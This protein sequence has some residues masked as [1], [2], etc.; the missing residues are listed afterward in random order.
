M[1][2]FDRYSLLVS[3]QF[4]KHVIEIMK[5]N[6]TISG[7][8]FKKYL[9]IILTVLSFSL[10][11]SVLANSVDSYTAACNAGPVYSVDANVSNVN[12]TSNYAWQYKNTSNVWVCI[13]NGNNFINGY[14]YSIS[15]ATS[16]ATTNPNPIMFNNPNSGLQG[17]VIRCV[18]SNGTGV[19]PCTM[20][21]GN[22]W[23]SGSSSNNHTI[24]VTGSACGTSPCTGRV[25]RLYFNELN[26]GAD[27]QITNGSSFTVAQL[28]SLY[29]LEAGTTGAIGSIKY[30]ITGPTPT[31]NIENTAPY[32]SPGTGSGAWT[33]TLGTYTVNLK[34]YSATGATGN[35]CHDTTISFT[36]TNTP[37]TLGGIS[38]GAVSNYLFVFTNGSVD[39]NWQSASKGFIGNVAV[40]GLQASERT[41]GSFAYAGTIYTNDASLGAWQ[42]IVNNNLSQ[43]SASLNRTSLLAGLENDLNS[44]F[45]QINALPVSPGYN[46]V[47][48]TALNGLNKQNGIAETFVININSGFGISSKIN[49]TGDAGDVFILRWDTD[50]NPANGYQGQVKFQS[51]GAIVPLGGLKPSNFI[52]VAGDIASSG[53]GSNPAAPYPQGPR[54]N[55]GTGSLINGG[56]DFSGGGFFTGYWFTTGDPVTNETSSLS[57]AIFVGGW[58][59][60]T[61][62]FSMT[63]GT[64]G[65]Y[66]TPPCGP[67]VNT[68]IGEAANFG[69]L[70]L[71]NGTFT[72]NSGTTLIANVGYSKGVTSGTNQKITTFTGT[73]YVHSLV[74]SFV[75]DATTYQ[76]SGGI[77]QNN[78]AAD[79][80]LNAA[81]VGAISGSANYASLTPN[82]SLGNVITNKTINRVNNVT[83][84][85]MAS[86]NYNSNTITFVGQAG[87][88]DA[89]IINVAGSF[90]FSQS[91]VV[92]TNVRP[93]RVVWNFPNASNIVINKASTIF[94]GTILAPLG[95]VIYHNPASFE[96]AI[97]AK[98]IAVHS[99]FNLTQKKLEIPCISNG[100]LSLGNEV[101]YDTNNNGINDAA[102][103][104]I[105]NVS[106]NLYTDSDNDNIADGPSIASSTTDING[107]YS[108]TGLSAGN[109][110][111]GV[112]I[113]NG[114]MSSSVNGGDP[115]NNID[116]DDNG[117]IAA[118]TEMRGLAIT[119]TSGAEPNGD[120]NNTYD[121]GFLPDCNCTT[122]SSN[123]LINGSFENGTTG[124]SWSGGNL[125][126][127]TG[128]VACGSANGFNNWSSGSSKV[129][130]DVAVS[131]GASVTFKGFAGTHTPGIACTPKL[132]LVFLNAANTVLGQSD[133]TVT[134]DVDINNSQL[135]QYSITSVA[136]AGTT[137]VRVQSTITCNTM[138]IDAFCL[139]VN[140]VLGSIGDRVWEDINRD[141]VQ[142]AGENGL[143]GITVKL[144]DNT[145][146]TVLGSTVTNAAGNYMFS[147]LATGVGTNYQ[148]GF[149][150]P[151]AQ[152]MFS[153]NNGAVTVAT[154]SD[155]NTTTGRTATITLTNAAPNVT[156][157]DAGMYRL[158]NING[159]VWND[160]NGLTDLQINRTGI[161]AIPNSLLVYLVDI[162]TNQVVQT[163]TIL[164]NGTYSF[165]DVEIN[166][167][168]KVVLSNGAP[169]PGNTSPIATLP[170]GWQRVGENLGAGPLSGSDGVP[171]G[172]LFIDTETS[173]V[174]DANF[175][176]RVSSGEIVVG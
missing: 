176:I 174:F 140:A 146:N 11:Q 13:L 8:T 1:L 169:G 121:F 29:N 109:Y 154:N 71:E 3:N 37:C 9:V 52:H 24:N 149:T 158:I 91:T 155:A 59:S 75:Y 98:N 41:S 104:G 172:Q 165:L 72:I 18:I 171:N 25:T 102:E 115:D 28:G 87:Q 100:T 31:S 161:Q 14:T 64:S 80:K 45:N 15:G 129:W 51:G 77:I 108:F 32:N 94:K 153:P 84:V 42:S 86:L 39:A 43:A 137:K 110:I 173:D 156:Y 50:M 81:N 62:K 17:L 79:I 101:W 151:S 168:Y 152:Y 116:N 16:T 33:G 124:W 107:N 131:A 105:R 128:Y 159:N 113:P 95:S 5:Q 48:A 49:I 22:T 117:Q 57:N 34:T 78:V 144:Y 99:D 66:V 58:Y 119:L 19:N 114:Y 92:L 167:S 53:G 126:T 88:D 166:H 70:G 157:V 103:N 134:R 139:N 138:K 120:T 63:S 36:L 60:K 136:P 10:S 4:I 89:F 68:C 123:L 148:V 162:A 12:S 150:L 7:V 145:T 175:G 54:T 142:D 74:N 27:L 67:P 65:V 164:P 40:D 38:L 85:S 143:A 35:L 163:E 21:A 90:D 96:G 118:G 122:S 83:V 135:E 97:I 130:Q 47:A 76:P 23:N 125:T 61:T 6:F 26:G 170:S 132:S 112:V 20:P 56:A 160:A 127:G 30:T 93:E 106:V 55:N 44:V 2:C 111:V 147:N 133:V 73:A 46:G 141:G 82:I 69:L